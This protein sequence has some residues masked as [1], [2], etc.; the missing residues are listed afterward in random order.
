[1]LQILPF[2]K[3]LITFPNLLPLVYRFI[4]IPLIGHFYS[5]IVIC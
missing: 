5:I 2:I 1:M 3:K 4:V